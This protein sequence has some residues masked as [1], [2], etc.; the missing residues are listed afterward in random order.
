MLTGEDIRRILQ[1]RGDGVPVVSLYA[2]SPANPH[3]EREMHSRVDSLLSEIRPIAT[4][5][6][7]GREARL[8]IRSDI[9]HILDHMTRHEWRPGSM[10]I[11]SCS[12][13]QIFEEVDL[14]DPVRDRIVL[15]T[16]P[17]TRPML[18]VLAQYHRMCMVTVDYGEATVWELYQDELREL[19]QHRDQ[20]L[21]KQ[22]PSSTRHD[23]LR[24]KAAEYSKKHLRE[25]AES[26]GRL[27]DT[28]AFDLLA[29]GGRPHEIP[30]F[31]DVLPN[32]LRQR[33]IAT[34]TV[35]PD[36][37]APAQIRERGIEILEKHAAD[38][39]RQRVAE[40][41]DTLGSGGRAT[42]GLE[43][44]LWACAAVAIDRLLVEYQAEAPGVVCDFDG[45]MGLGGTE[46]PVCGRPVRAA[47]DIVDEMVESVI[48]GGGSV[49]QVKVETDLRGHLAGATLHFPLPPEP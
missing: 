35:D 17:W 20:K 34:F 26:V 3:N 15:D 22:S 27:F 7:V 44:C 10:A 48:D 47:A 49:T 39:Q 8:S 29:V 14:P 13:R 45:W 30:H 41:F 42:L 9:E 2:Q 38:E 16:T 4:D 24:D 31:L 19:H 28:E 21:R 23:E 18:A 11:F 40:L 1:V 12:G 25:A 43:S 6:S 5:E 37:P 33:V 32:D 46:C 36:E